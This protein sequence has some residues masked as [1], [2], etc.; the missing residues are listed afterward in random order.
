MPRAGSKMSQV[1]KRAP[2]LG[3]QLKEAIGRNQEQLMRALPAE[4]AA[5]VESRVH[6]KKRI[7]LIVCGL[8]FLTDKIALTRPKAALAGGSSA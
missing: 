3:P 7:E 8:F 6:R 5:L 1:K 2:L 4:K